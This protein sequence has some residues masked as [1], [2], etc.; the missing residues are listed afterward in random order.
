MFLAF[1]A[2]VGGPLLLPDPPGDATPLNNLR[3]AANYA[4]WG[5]WFPLVFLSV[6]FTGRAWCGVLCPMGAASELVNR[7]GLQRPIPRWLSW[8]GTPLVSFIFITMLGQTLGVRDHP[9]AAAEILGGTMLAAIVIGFLFG[10]RKRAWCRHMCPIGRVLGLYSRL[11]AVQFEPRVRLPGGDM[12]TERGVCP[13]MIDLPHKTE[14][15]HCITCFRCVN[16]QAKGGIAMTLRH[17]GAEIE[18]I[19]EHHASFSEVWFLFLDTGVAL[20]GFLWLVLPAYQTARQ[21]VGEWAITHDWTWMVEV[22]PSWLMSEHPARAE[23]F[24][25]LDFIMI[26]GFMAACMLAMT[27]VLAALT[28][29]ASAL[30][31]RAGARRNFR[32]CFTELGYQFAPVALMSLVIGLGAELFEP[33]RATVLGP[34]GVSGVKGGLFVIGLLWSVWLALRIL[35]RQGVP[36]GQRWKPLLPGLIGS[37]AAGLAWWPAIFGA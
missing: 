6:I 12:R 26:V 5:I 7:V 19:A 20:G 21:A 11:G 4:L 34:A 3:V 13:M 32:A 24:L 28:A 18:A 31:V 14:S 27:T 22:G 29:A 2:V 36:L 33:L 10:R 9:E 30:A 17:P 35:G 16:P 37:V 23:T 1:L 25:W 8:E 15:R